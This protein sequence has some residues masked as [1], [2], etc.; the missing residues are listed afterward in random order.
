MGETGLVRAVVPLNLGGIGGER[1]ACL[2]DGADRA[3]EFARRTGHRERRF[4]EVEALRD[5]RLTEDITRAFLDEV[6][7]GEK[8]YFLH[9]NANMTVKHFLPTDNSSTSQ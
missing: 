3:G 4:S 2:R 1:S 9:D 7:K 8:Q 5:M 6:L